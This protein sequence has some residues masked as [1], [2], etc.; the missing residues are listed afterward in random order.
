MGL[1]LGRLGNPGSLP[2]TPTTFNRHIHIPAF[3]VFWK[4]AKGVCSNYLHLRQPLA[5]QWPVKVPISTYAPWPVALVMCYRGLDMTP[6]QGARSTW[7]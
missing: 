5:S 6:R 2:L 7:A 1:D 4:S 3:G